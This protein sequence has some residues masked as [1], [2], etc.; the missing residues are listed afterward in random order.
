MALNETPKY[1]ASNTLAE[2]RW[3]DTTVLSGDLAA[4]IGRL[5]AKPAG[6]LQVHGSGTLVR[7][8]L[9]NGLVDEITLL[10]VPVIL[11][12][13]TRLFPA[14]GPGLPAGRAPAVCGSLKRLRIPRRRTRPWS[15]FVRKIRQIYPQRRTGRLPFDHGV[16]IPGGGD[17]LSSSSRTLGQRC[18]PVPRTWRH[19]RPGHVSGGVSA[20]GHGPAIQQSAESFAPVTVPPQGHG[21]LPQVA[22][23][24]AVVRGI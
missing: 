7:W 22:A 11:G 8:L 21:G 24:R 15:S 3:A 20:M 9:E 14:I 16:Q 4:A 6:E 2:P 1:V 19:P 23:T 5:K 18:G 17:A 12:Q 10:I 13:G